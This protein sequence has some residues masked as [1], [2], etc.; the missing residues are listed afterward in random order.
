MIVRRSLTRVHAG[1]ID[2]G[3]YVLGACS[4]IA[5]MA[6][7]IGVFN[8][9]VFLG[10]L[11]KAYGLSPVKLSVGSTLFYVWTGLVGLV[12]GQVI[13]RVGPRRV[14]IVG[15]IA[16]SM[17]ALGLGLTRLLWHIYPAFLLLGTGYGCM[18]TVTLG[19]IIARWFVQDRT[20]A[21]GII[22]LSGSLGGML[23]TPLNAA[24]LERWGGMAGGLTLAA[25]AGGVIMP[26]AIWVIKNDPDDVD[27]RL[28]GE[29]LPEER[30]ESLTE[31][32]DEHA[33]PFSAA[34]RTAAFWAYAVS[35][36]LVMMAQIGF[37]T[38]QVL[39]LQPTFGLLRSATVLTVTTCMAT[40][41]GIGFALWGNRGSLRQWAA[42]AYGLQAA[43]LLVSAVSDVPWI[44]LVGSATF[45]LP[46]MI[47]VSLQPV[48]TAECFGQR[49]FGHIYGP[50]Y[51]GGRLGSAVGPLLIG[52]MATAMGSYQPALLAMAA[53]PCVAILLLPLATTPAAHPL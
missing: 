3:W 32:L 21:M 4:L 31:T 29:A 6:W 30:A 51:F 15:A 43:G 2:Y 18:H 48:M 26:L 28:D 22:T 9:S 25:I 42:G 35:F 34:M 39:F 50:L 12:V 47:I 16:L 40:L 36:L 5:V 19:A 20:R 46:M 7:G 24:V 41:G 13:D 44:L 33:W 45:G 10:F 49:S 38:H 37:L 27:M 17:G 52:V 14:L 23:L 11:A 8:Q 1:R 53:G